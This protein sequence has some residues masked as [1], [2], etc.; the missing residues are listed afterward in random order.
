MK[1][2]GIFLCL[3][4]DRNFIDPED[5]LKIQKR[6]IRYNVKLVMSHPCLCSKDTG[7]PV[8]SNLAKNVDKVVIV[9]CHKRAQRWLFDSAI[10]KDKLIPINLRDSSSEDVMDELDNLLPMKSEVKTEWFPVIDKDRCIECGQCM[11]FCLF[12]A[13]DK[14]EEGKVYVKN[15]YNCKDNCPACAR[16]CPKGAIIFPK[17]PEDWVSGADV[18]MPEYKKL[19]RYEIIEELKKKRGIYLTGA[20][21]VNKRTK[22]S[23]KNVID[24]L[25]GED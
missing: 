3:C 11:D 18:P 2:Y 8:L 7:L 23:I 19:S 10:E 17:C 12:G 4:S 9:A 6:T 22:K 16:V 24:E 1:R 25:G 5:I 20:K 21:T 13:F 14:D 15:P